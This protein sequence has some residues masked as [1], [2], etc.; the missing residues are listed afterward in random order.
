VFICVA[1]MHTTVVCVCGVIRGF[2]SVFL[3]LRVL[4]SEQAGLCS[5]VAKWPVY[6]AV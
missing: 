3:L 5:N 2:K 6:K 1:Y 4:V